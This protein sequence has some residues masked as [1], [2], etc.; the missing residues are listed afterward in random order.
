MHDIGSTPAPPPPE[1]PAAPQ[2]YAT[3]GAQGTPLP[4]PEPP[5]A[6][7]PYAT[8]G[9][10]GTPLPPPNYLVWAILS[11]I[12]CFLPLGIASVVFAAQVNG[13]WAMGDVDGAQGA[14]AKAKALAVWAAIVGVVLYGIAFLLGLLLHGLTT[15]TVS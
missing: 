9:A 2:P 12:L 14:S 6:P 5:A 3:S 11:T 13:K 10:Q 7:Q 1:P 15:L 4:P 8:S